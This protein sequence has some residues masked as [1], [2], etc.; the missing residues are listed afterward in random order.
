MKI[1]SQ[2]LHDSNLAVFRAHYGSHHF[3]GLIIR[4]EPVGQRATF[5][6]LVMTLHTLC[7]PCRKILLDAGRCSLWLYPKG[8]S[9][10]IC[11]WG[12]FIGMCII[13]T[14]YGCSATVQGP[15][16]QGVISPPAGNVFLLM[17]ALVGT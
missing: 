2:R 5:E 11:A 16:K 1:S 15:L 13:A 8:V 7:C 9:A 14:I 4:I 12:R 17:S 6:A 3:G 10:Q